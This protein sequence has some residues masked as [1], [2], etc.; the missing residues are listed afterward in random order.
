MKW[1]RDVSLCSAAILS[2]SATGYAK[3]PFG[4]AGCGLGSLVI[5][6]EGGQIS[7]V[8]TNSSFLSQPLGITFGTSNCLEPHEAAA[9]TAQQ[10]F[11]QENYSTLS[12]EMAQGEGEALHAFASTFGCSENVREEFAA[13]MQKSYERIFSAP[14]SIASLNVVQ[15]ELK[16]N[17]TLAQNCEYTG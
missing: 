3:T 8:T 12:K 11:I 9:L 2:L 10:E 14:G 17:K 16:D 5:S 13:Q 6:P 1:A 4:M 15:D 7:A